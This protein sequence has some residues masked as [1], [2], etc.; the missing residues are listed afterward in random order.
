MHFFWLIISLSSSGT[1]R[2]QVGRVPHCV[3]FTSNGKGNPC[4][5]TYSWNIWQEIPGKQKGG[6]NHKTKQNPLR[7]EAKAEMLKVVIAGSAQGTLAAWLLLE[8]PLQK[9]LGKRFQVLLCWLLFLALPFWK[10]HNQMQK[11][12]LYLNIDPKPD[13]VFWGKT[14]REVK[15]KEIKCIWLFR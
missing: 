12:K 1:R 8:Q 6:K 14:W 11:M 5:I 4:L 7:S 2:L 13:F 9:V 3:L 15:L 10:I